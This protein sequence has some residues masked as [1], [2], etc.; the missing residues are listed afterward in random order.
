MSETTPNR[1]ST[2]ITIYRLQP[3]YTRWVYLAW[4][5]IRWLVGR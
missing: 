5:T 3:W 2:S 4:D 1:A